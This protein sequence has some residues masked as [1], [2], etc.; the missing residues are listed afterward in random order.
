MGRFAQ[1][2]EDRLATLLDENDFKNTIKATNVFL[3]IFNFAQYL[4]EKI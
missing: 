2:C 1:L 3:L 4:N